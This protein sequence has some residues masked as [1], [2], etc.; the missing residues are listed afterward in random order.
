MVFDMMK[1]GGYD[2]RRYVTL[3]A[4]KICHRNYLTFETTLNHYEIGAYLVTGTPQVNTFNCACIVEI[5][6]LSY[7]IHSIY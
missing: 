5:I 2:T 4:R 3:Y 6:F 7:I 1:A